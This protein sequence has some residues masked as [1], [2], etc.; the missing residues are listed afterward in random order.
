MVSPYRRVAI[1]DN[2]GY[3]IK[4]PILALPVCKAGT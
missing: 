4:P 2:R 3:A 1:S